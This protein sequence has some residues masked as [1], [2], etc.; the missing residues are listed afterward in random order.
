MK[1]IFTI[2]L[3]FLSG[4]ASYAQEVFPLSNSRWTELLTLG[5]YPHSTTIFFSYV[6]QGDTIIDGI[7]RSKVY[8]IP[9]INK[10]DSLLTG[11]FH[12]KGKVIYYR[13]DVNDVTDCWLGRCEIC[14]EFFGKDY[15]LYD[16]SLEEGD[17]YVNSFGNKLT[18]NSVDTLVINGIKRKRINFNDSGSSCWIEGMGSNTGLFR[19]VEKTPTSAAYSRSFACFSHNGTVLYLGHSFPD[20]PQANFS[21]LNKIDQDSVKVFFNHHRHTISI[22]SPY[23]IKRVKVFNA[24][25]LLLQEEKINGE[26]QIVLHKCMLTSGVYIVNIVFQDGKNEIRK[27]LIR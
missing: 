11:Y 7:Q 2:C 5:E 13:Q 16:F 23:A 1:S 17:T 10:R 9:D 4:L 24:N 14:D 26:F 6:L 22:V 27:L 25:G 12:T 21:S 15:P 8:F 20:C 19:H 18:V 3:L